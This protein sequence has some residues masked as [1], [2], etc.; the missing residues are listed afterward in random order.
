MGS[1]GQY[2]LKIHP[3]NL[4]W[5]FPYVILLILKNWITNELRR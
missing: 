1:I 5:D 3:V 4:Q 2:L